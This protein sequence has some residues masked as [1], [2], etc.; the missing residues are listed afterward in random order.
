VLA[1]DLKRLVDVG[2]EIALYSEDGGMTSAIGSLAGL[3]A[4]SVLAETGPR[5]FTSL[6][7]VDLIDALVTVTAGGVAG[8]QAPSL[9]RGE[10]DSTDALPRRMYALEAGVAGSVVAVQWRRAAWRRQEGDR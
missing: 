7:E 9:F 10:E 2:A 1:P 5:T 8:A 6:W 4:V 3:G